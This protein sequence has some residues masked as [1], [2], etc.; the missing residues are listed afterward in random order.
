MEQGRKKMP[1]I[2]VIVDDL[3]DIMSEAT[4]PNEIQADLDRLVSMARAAGIHLLLSIQR[5]SS[6]IVSGTVKMNIPNR[7]AFRTVS[8]N[9]SRLIIQ[10]GGAEHLNGNG[11]ML[12]KQLGKQEPLR[13]QGPYISDEEIDY[14]VKFVL[15]NNSYY[16]FNNPMNSMIPDSKKPSNKEASPI[17]KA[18]IMTSYDELLED[19]GRIII[20]KQKASVGMIQR[21]FKLGFNRAARIMDQLAE[22]G[23]VGPEDGV[24]PRKILVNMEEYEKIIKNS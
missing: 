20:V 17:D 13:I 8:G 6:D 3:A 16:S 10:A 18:D 15:R 21:V 12:F 1:E 4:Y 2:L 5:P 19:A 14:V 22:L 24:N 9:D 23:V 11:D 7:I